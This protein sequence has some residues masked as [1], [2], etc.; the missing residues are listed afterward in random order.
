MVSRVP[1]SDRRAGEQEVVHDTESS[2]IPRNSAVGADPEFCRVH[3]KPEFGKRSETGRHIAAHSG[4]VS[5][6][7]K[8]YNVH[9]LTPR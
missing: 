8:R 2:M 9:V 1:S 3:G 6:T 5:P 7:M 4:C